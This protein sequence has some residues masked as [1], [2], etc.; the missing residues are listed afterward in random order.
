MKF[1]PALALEE[2]AIWTRWETAF[3]A[4]RATVES[5]PALPEDRARHETLVV[6]LREQLRIDPMKSVSANAT[7]RALPHSLPPGVMRPLE[8]RWIRC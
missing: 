4:G 2:W 7:F 3:H 8:V 1:S 5:H 6:A